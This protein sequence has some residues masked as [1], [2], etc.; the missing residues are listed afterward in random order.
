MSIRMILAALAISLI[1]L[2][3]P[4]I[5]ADEESKEKIISEIFDVMQYEKMLDQ[6]FAVTGEQMISQLKALGEDTDVD[7]EAVF[8]EFWDEIAE[9]LKTGIRPFTSQL[10]AKHYTEEELKELLEFYRSDVG[11]KSIET[12]P[13]IMQ[14][15]MA[16]ANQKLASSV[17]Q[18]KERIEARVKA[19]M[20][21]REED[22]NP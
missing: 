18:M 19:A 11:R 3:P 22:S 5:Q 15:T 1:V 16:W 17:P 7:L 13:Q 21:A 4:A 9:E 14:E 2:S 8:G 12:A 10:W 20:E 6:M